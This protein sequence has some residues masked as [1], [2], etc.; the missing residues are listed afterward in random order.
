MPAQREY[1]SNEVN[2]S[3]AGYVID[4]GYADGVFLEVEYRNPAF[5]LTKGTDGE[6]TRSRTN[7]RSATI[8][9]HLMQGARG[10]AVLT[11]LH[12][13]DLAAQ[14][15][16]GVGALDITDKNGTTVYF[17]EKAFISSPPNASYDRTPTERVWEI[18]ANH[19]IAVEG[20][21]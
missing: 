6:G 7:D 20:S 8:R 3:I 11:A 21:Y 15:G 4:G 5:E 2:I 16:A 18:T 13:L 14:N 19:L 10:N 9:V 17:A 1:S 12:Q